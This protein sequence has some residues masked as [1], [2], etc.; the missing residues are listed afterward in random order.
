MGVMR[1]TKIA[2]IS[3]VLLLAVM[4][5]FSSEPAQA[6]TARLVITLIRC[7]RYSGVAWMSPIRPSAETVSPSIASGEKFPA[8]AASAS[9]QRNTPFSP[10]P[11][12]PTPTLSAN[13][14][15]NTPTSG[16]REAGCSNF[17]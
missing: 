3:A 1:L 11:V 5:G 14:A 6:A 2:G 4:A 7:A 17:W 12:T 8:S 9:S 16:K 13:F 15:T 10:A